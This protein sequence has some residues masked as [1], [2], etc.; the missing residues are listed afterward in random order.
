MRSAG[1]WRCRGVRRP[2]S[3]ARHSRFVHNPLEDRLSLDEHTPLGLDEEVGHRLPVERAGGAVAIPAPAL[4]RQQ[5]LD[6]ATVAA[7]ESPAEVVEGT[8]RA[9]YFERRVR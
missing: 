4:V 2:L 8:V 5:V 3:V 1:S 6:R 9:C 7:V